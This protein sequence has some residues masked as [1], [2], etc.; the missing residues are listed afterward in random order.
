MDNKNFE[1]E[2]LTGMF[3]TNEIEQNKIIT[4]LAYI[5]PL[6]FI[7][8]ISSGT[9][10]YARFH[11][12]QACIVTLLSAA[13]SVLTHLINFFV[14]WI[15]VIGVIV[16][17]VIAIVLGLSI[18]ALIIIGIV[19]AVGGKAKKLPIVGNLIGIIK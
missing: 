17:T 1:T 13:Y 7:P 11:A 15:P 9:S 12:N 2:D 3:D 19:N 5:P 14:G 16:S 6:F 18:T 8:L 10:K 4:V